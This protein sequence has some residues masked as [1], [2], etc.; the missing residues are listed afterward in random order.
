M[1]PTVQRLRGFLD[2]LYPRG[3]KKVV[4]SLEL[5]LDESGWTQQ[6]VC[7]IAGYLASDRQWIRLTN[8]W[9]EVRTSHNA[10][11]F[12][13]HDFFTL[14]AFKHSYPGWTRG[15][16]WKYLSKLIAIKRKH[17]LTEINTAVRAS[18]FSSLSV[19][20]RRFVTGGQLRFS[21]RDGKI[22]HGKWIKSGGPNQ[23]YYLCLISCLFRVLAEIPEH[24]VLH[25]YMDEQRQLAPY[26]LEIHR[27]FKIAF[28]EHRIGDIAFS[29]RENSPP[30]QLADMISY[31]RFQEATECLTDHEQNALAGLVEIRGDRL[32][33]VERGTIDAIFGAQPKVVQTRFQ[34]ESL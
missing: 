10:P 22:T 17:R 23:A 18:L 13:A 14:E 25:L 12:H 8:A 27:Q 16:G 1:T 5:H 32:A 9:E 24:L 2:S 21:G 28:A 29:T 31:L 4:V 7:V 11:P 19:E 26:A 20:Q 3:R 15:Q 34:H 33:Y 6:S 30:L